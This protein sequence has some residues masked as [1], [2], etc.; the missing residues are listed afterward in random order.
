MHS[1]YVQGAHMLSGTTNIRP[2]VYKVSKQHKRMPPE[3][4][5]YKTCFGCGSTGHQITEFKAFN[6]TWEMSYEMLSVHFWI[7]L[8]SIFTI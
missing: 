5:T 2:E 7:R 1:L 3:K 8:V 6:Y 4:T